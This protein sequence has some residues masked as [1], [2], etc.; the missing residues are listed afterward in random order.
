MYAIVSNKYPNIE[1]YMSYLILPLM[2]KFFHILP[3]WER[4]VKFHIVFSFQIE[5][6]KKKKKKELDLYI[7][8]CVFLGKYSLVVNSFWGKA[9]AFFS[10]L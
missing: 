2:E 9:I 4:K 10:V 1:L 5:T 6:G 7:V 3:G 8:A